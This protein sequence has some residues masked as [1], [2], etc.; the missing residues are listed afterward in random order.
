MFRKVLVFTSDVIQTSDHNATFQ[1]IL[2]SVLICNQLM[3]TKKHTSSLW[4]LSL[5]Y[6]EK[7]E[8]FLDE[9]HV[10]SYFYHNI[11]D[12]SQ[13]HHR[14]VRV[15]KGSNNKSSAIAVFH[16]CDSKLQHRFLLKE[17]VSLS[18]KKIKSLLDSLGE[19]LR[20]FDQA[21][22]VSQ[23]PLPIHKLEIGFRNAKDELFIH[24]YRDIVEHLNRQI[25]LS[26]RFQKTRLA[27]FPSKRL[28]NTVT[29]SFLQKFSTWVTAKSNI[30]TRNDFLL[31][32]G[33][34]L[35]RALTMCSAFTPLVGMTIA[36]LFSLGTCIFQIRSVRVNFACTK[37]L[38]NL[39]A[40]A[41]INV[42]N[43]RLCASSSILLLKINQTPFSCRLANGFTFW[44]ESEINSKCF[45]KCVLSW[46]VL[47]QQKEMRTSWRL[48]NNS[49]IKLRL[50]KFWSLVVCSQSSFYVTRARED[51]KNRQNVLFLC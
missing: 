3:S 12:I 4:R 51:D 28:N 20:A 33:V 39:S 30:S 49:D 29:S 13:S 40:E 42:R 16:F 21:K 32:T 45:W 47:F 15:S 37:R 24:C 35:L 34:T 26:F 43:A 41:I 9:T 38:F 36:K 27:F 2:H 10:D 23:I 17:E 48:C 19:F 14:I 11:L 18:K 50:W 5:V 6:D 25:R 44:I 1:F 46:Q 22:K 8:Q 7:P 31:L